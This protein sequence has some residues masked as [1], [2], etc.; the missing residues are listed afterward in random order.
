MMT[1]TFFVMEHW[2]T[3]ACTKLKTSIECIA[4]H[5]M[6]ILSPA[7]KE[8]E[9]EEEEEEEEEVDGFMT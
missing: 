5:Q 1:S 3:M 2:Q 4:N 9:T 7:D 8:G 6:R